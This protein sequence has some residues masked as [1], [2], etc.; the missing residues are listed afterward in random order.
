MII[1]NE[2]NNSR[3]TRLSN[4]NIYQAGVRMHVI[5]VS[6]GHGN[7]WTEKAHALLTGAIMITCNALS[8]PIFRFWHWLT[9]FFFRFY[10]CFRFRRCWRIG[11]N[12][13]RRGWINTK[14]KHRPWM[15]RHAA[16]GPRPQAGSRPLPVF[17]R[18]RRLLRPVHPLLRVGFY[19]FSRACSF[20][21][22]WEI[23][24]AVSDSDL[25]DDLDMDLVGGLLKLRSEF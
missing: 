16:H 10:F 7:R 13:N 22:M 1:A 11:H 20:A 12:A 2:S 6:C 14:I 5:S 8:F 25:V 15:P 9:R 24:W 3:N 18:T 23:S 4:E 21:Y 19:F 17:A